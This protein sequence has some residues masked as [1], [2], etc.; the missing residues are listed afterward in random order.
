MRNIEPKNN[1][2]EG[3]ESYPPN[4]GY[5]YDLIASCDGSS[6]GGGAFWT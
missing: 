6:D 3:F 2:I 1:G 4:E 5:S